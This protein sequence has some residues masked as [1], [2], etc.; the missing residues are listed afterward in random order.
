MGA[1]LVS[2]YQYAAGKGG[3][4]MQVKL[5]MKTGVSQPK[6]TEQSDNLEMLNLFRTTLLEITGNAEDVPQF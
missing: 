4:M 5:A 2:Y 1:K 6:A 3:L